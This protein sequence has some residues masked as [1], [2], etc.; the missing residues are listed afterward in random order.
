M[1]IYYFVTASDYF[2]YYSL[3]PE[4][5]LDGI[6]L[7]DFLIKHDLTTLDVKLAKQYFQM[8]KQNIVW[9]TKDEVINA[10]GYK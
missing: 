3:Y 10:K 1:G 6:D 5:M 4:L 9:S 2:G 7:K 8:V